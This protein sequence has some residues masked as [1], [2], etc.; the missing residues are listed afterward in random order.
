[1]YKEPEVLKK[2]F[3]VMILSKGVRKNFAGDKTM[4][5]FKFYFH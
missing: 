3:K 5:S 4:L 1:M 2:N